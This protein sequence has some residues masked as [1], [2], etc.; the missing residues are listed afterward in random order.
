MFV[1]GIVLLLWLGDIG[2]DKAEAIW[3]CQRCDGVKALKLNLVSSSN[4]G[5]AVGDVKPDLP[6]ITLTA[7]TP[8]ENYQLWLEG[9]TTAGLALKSNVVAFVTQTPLEFNGKLEFWFHQ[10]GLD[11]FILDRRRVVRDSGDQ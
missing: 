5:P 2:S 6:K 8:R 7:L 9:V 10:I 4:S 3:E 1:P 11:G